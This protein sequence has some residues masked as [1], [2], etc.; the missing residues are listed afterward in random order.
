MSGRITGAG[1]GVRPEC[2]AA[3]DLHS[4]RQRKQAAMKGSGESSPS[5]CGGSCRRE[6]GSASAD[7]EGLSR[8]H[9]WL[10]GLASGSTH[11]QGLSF[12]W[13]HKSLGPL[14]IPTSHSEAG[15]GGLSPGGRSVPGWPWQERLFG[16]EHVWG[17]RSRSLGLWFRPLSITPSD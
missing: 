6:H 9:P 7:R 8:W 1:G 11:Q 13:L 17:H 2:G 15:G 16:L 5:S 12:L 4:L 14:F 10:P 3:L